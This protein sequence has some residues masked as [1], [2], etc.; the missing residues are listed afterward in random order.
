MLLYK[1]MMN[2]FHLGNCFLFFWDD[3]SGLAT[4]EDIREGKAHMVWYVSGLRETGSPKE[5]GTISGRLQGSWLKK[6]R[7]AKKERESHG[8]VT[9][10]NTGSGAVTQG[11]STRV[12]LTGSLECH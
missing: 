1:S 11:K 12:F 2:K 4:R 5:R 3:Q 9:S 8:Q 7:R 10:D 6:A